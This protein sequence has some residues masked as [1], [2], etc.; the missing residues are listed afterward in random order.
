VA[1]EKV[2]TYKHQQTYTILSDEDIISRYS[3]TFKILTKRVMDTPRYVCVLC[4]T[5]F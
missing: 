2:N 1:Q 3:K 5:L 4:E